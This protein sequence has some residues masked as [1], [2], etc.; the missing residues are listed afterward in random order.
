MSE[1]NNTHID[2]AKDI[3][4][5]LPMYSWMKYSDN[6]LKT[7]GRLWK[8]YGDERALNA[9]GGIIDFPVSNNS[10]SL[11]FKQ[12]IV[13]QT[14]NDGT[15]HVEKV[16]ELKHLSNFWK[17]LTIPLNCCEINLI[18]T[19]SA[20]CFMIANAIESHVWTFS[21][22]DTKIYVPVVTLST[23]DNISVLDQLK[24]GFKKTINWNKY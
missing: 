13:G 5:V 22:T 15:K 9:A 12:K 21:I 11:K 3:N 17:T 2:N 1:I 23:Q 10:V 16:V 18:L 4:V 7:Y 14:G 8:Y 20:D 24:S 6:Y 19:W